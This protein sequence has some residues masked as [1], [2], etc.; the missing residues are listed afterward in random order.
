MKKP[1][2]DLV[3]KWYKK[4]KASGF[5]D[6]E[7]DPS[8]PYMQKGRI[9]MNDVRRPHTYTAEAFD[10]AR[11]YYE[12]ATHILERERMYT[13]RNELRVREMHAAGKSGPQIAAATGLTRHAVWVLV[14]AF[15]HQIQEEAVYGKAS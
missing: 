1:S 9:R 7:A 12:V 13:S 5:E 6:I 14:S 2:P 8:D 15:K 11:R 4:L 3:A 10:A